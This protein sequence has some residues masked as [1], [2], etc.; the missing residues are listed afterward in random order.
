[1]LKTL[2]EMLI[3]SPR[4]RVDKSLDLSSL[5]RLLVARGSPVLSDQP[6][7]FR[8]AGASTLLP[9]LITYI[10]IPF[11]SYSIKLLLGWGGE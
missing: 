6:G 3:T 8:A 11:S 10:Q 1:M 9:L 4:P 7:G 2:P 5:S